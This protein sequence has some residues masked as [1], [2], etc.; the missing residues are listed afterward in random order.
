M[1]QQITDNVFDIRRLV[2]RFPVKDGFFGHGKRVVHAI[3]DFSLTVRRGETLGIVGE[4]GCGKSTLART[5]MGLASISSGEIQFRPQ[6][7]KSTA[8]EYNLA[9]ASSADWREVRRKVQIVFQDPYSSLSP[10]QQVGKIIGEPLIVQGI[11]GWQDKVRALLELVGLSHRDF[12]RYPH[13]FSG[14]QRQRIM[15]ARAIALDP[16]VLIADEAVSA[17]DVSIRIQIINLLNRLKQEL[18]LTLIFISHDLGVVRLIS[19]RIAIMYLGHLAEI[20]GNEEIFKRSRHP[21]T[22]MLIRSTPIPDPDQRVAFTEARGEVPSPITPPSGCVFHTR[23]S[24]AKD[25]CKQQEPQPV[26]VSKSHSAFC[27]FNL[28]L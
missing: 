27:H 28:S 15:I 12:D 20:G 21:Y 1:E 10:K 4:S 22:R 25:L 11:A 3:E 2:V 16:E 17:L 6:S 23:C 5:L 24:F 7:D 9:G 18:G 8:R 19:D 14:G 13:E 26:P